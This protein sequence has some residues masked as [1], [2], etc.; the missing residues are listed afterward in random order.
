M[1]L[2]ND[3]VICEVSNVLTGKTLSINDLAEKMM[4]ITKIKVDIKL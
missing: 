4:D 1:M 2:T 3:N